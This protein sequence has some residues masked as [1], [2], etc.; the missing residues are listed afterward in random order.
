MKLAAY[1]SSL[2]LKRSIVSGGP[3]HR[4]RPVRHRES[5]VTQGVPPN[6]ITLA[7]VAHSKPSENYL[8]QLRFT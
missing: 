7:E 3:V 4:C 6:E 8:W 1:L 5:V 2:V